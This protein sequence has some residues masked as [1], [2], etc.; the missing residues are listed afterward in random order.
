MPKYVLSRITQIR[1]RVPLRS[2]MFSVREGQKLESDIWKAVE[3]W[4]AQREFGD[5]KYVPTKNERKTYWHDHWK[6][7]RM[8]DFTSVRI[9]LPRGARK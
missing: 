8:S 6:R 7:K 3:K 4:H 9:R 5:S 2:L 1:Q